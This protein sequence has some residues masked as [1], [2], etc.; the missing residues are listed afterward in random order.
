MLIIAHRGASGYAP[1]NT[2]AAFELAIDQNADGMEL[3][4]HLTKDGEVVICHDD[5]VK[6]TTNSQGLI[7]DMTL[8]EL[9][10]LDAGSWY[11]ESFRGI[12]IP[13]LQEFMA[14]AAD[15]HMLI[16][17][18]IKNLP[19]YHKGIEQKLIRSV[20]EHDMLDRVVISSFDHYALAETA[21]LEP[22]MKLGVLFSTRVI[23]PWDYVRKLPFAAYSL[24]PH[25]SFVDVEYIRQC[26]AHGYKVYPYTV[27]EAEW[28]G[29]LAQAGL[30]GVITNYPDR[31]R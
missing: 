25:Y 12:T 24:H 19:Y 18:E 2:I 8:E 3:D 17:L 21:R 27:N 15:T 11:G 22:A 6:R 30:D 10:R 26:H 23:D 20:H 5:D 28:A 13:T 9:R 7:K 29:P 14:L 31:F 16:N 1:E 4:V